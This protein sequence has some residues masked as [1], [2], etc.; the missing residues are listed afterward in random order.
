[1]FAEVVELNLGLPIGVSL[2]DIV[3]DR[4]VGDLLLDQH[5]LNVIT[6]GLIVEARA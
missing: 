1:M 4:Q 3:L 2:A 6:D 5:H